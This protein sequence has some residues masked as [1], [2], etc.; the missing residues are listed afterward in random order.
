MPVVTAVLPS[1]A[2]HAASRED[3]PA[4]ADVELVARARAGDLR[5]RE[6]IYRHHVQVVAR[7]ARRLLRER[8]D[9]EDVVQETFVIAFEQLDR[10]DQPGALRGWLVR[11]AIS[12]VHRR[13][14]WH[15]WTRL[16]TDRELDASL[17]D[18]ASPDASPAQR[19][20]LAL[21][22]RVLGEMA[23]KLRIPWVLRH[24]LGESLDDV[25]A[26]CGCSLATV[27]R[28]LAAAEALVAKHVDGGRL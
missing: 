14:R 27:K 4:A 21:I 24:V 26:G 7:T 20:E 6:L 28:R 25:A 17:Y 19:A 18:Q 13:F 1:F 10:L 2:E 15:R 5:A 9:A 11:I 3:A 22:D 8:A 16:W 12:R 23:L